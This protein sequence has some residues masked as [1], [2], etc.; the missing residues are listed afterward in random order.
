MGRKMGLTQGQ[1]QRA[2]AEGV[3]TELAL[4]QIEK[5]SRADEIP[6]T[7]AC[8][9]DADS[10]ASIAAALQEGWIDLCHDDGAAW[11]YLGV[12]PDCQAQEIE[13]AEPEGPPPDPQKHLFG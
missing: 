5:N 10:P 13:T 6:E 9:C 7:I 1:I 2:K 11:N 3:T 12:C 8:R 4:R